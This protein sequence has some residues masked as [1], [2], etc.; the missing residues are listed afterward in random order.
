VTVYN[1]I[2]SQSLRNAT[3]SDLALQ[4]A[5]S[6]PDREII[7][8][9]DEPPITNSAIVLEAQQLA[10]GLQQL[11]MTAGDVISFQLPSWREAVAIDLA[12]SML[13]LVVNPIIPIY[14]ERE[15]RFI[16][17]DAR[18]RLLFIPQTFRSVDYPKMITSLR[19]ELPDLEHVVVVRGAAN[20]DRLTRQ[21]SPHNSS[22]I[23][24]QTLTDSDSANL[25]TAAVNPESLKVLMYTS[26][27]TGTPK[28]VMH[29]HNSLARAIDNTLEAW[30]LDGA[31]LMLMPSPV[32]HITGYVNGIELPFFSDVKTLLMN[33]WQVARAAELIQRHA[34]TLC[35]S[36]TPF[37]QELVDHAEQHN[38]DLSSL[39]L[40]ACGGAAVPPELIRRVPQSLGQCRAFRVYGSTEVPLVSTGFTR[41]EQLELA[42]TTDG[43]IDNWQVRVVDAEGRD[44]AA[45]QDGELWIRGPAMMLGYKDPGQTAAA[46][47]DGYFHTGDIGHITA[48]N[49][50]VIT[51]RKKDLII[52]G[53]ENIS[54]KE[55]E[56]VLHDH[57]RI[58]EAAVVAMPHQRLGECV[59]AFLVIDGNAPDDALI[60]SK[61]LQPH[62]SDAGLARQKWPEKIVLIDNFERTASGKIRKNLLRAKLAN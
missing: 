55:V 25:Q 20:G 43:K 32:T 60:N 38:D 58:R 46:M 6:D 29:S 27:T 35:I 51:D 61:T 9:E 45:G 56:D 49:A 47:T 21:T 12:A 14:R 44:M 24:Y 37:L 30:H 41:P 2:D 15:L 52:R 28:A 57:P 39:R 18:T 48:D 22:Q 7:L 54:A 26:G 8:L 5:T 53:G 59:C 33:Q 42:A 11:G 19:H 50:V 34:A 23:D 13:G 31:D 1:G 62:L 4:R 10:T 17:G 36:A 40:F 16:L 3:V